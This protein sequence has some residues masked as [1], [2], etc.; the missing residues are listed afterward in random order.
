METLM[1]FDYASRLDPAVILFWR[2]L[3]F[4]RLD[5]CFCTI[6]ANLLSSFQ[7]EKSS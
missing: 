1:E 2:S 4:F 7:P 3:D 5:R 6:W